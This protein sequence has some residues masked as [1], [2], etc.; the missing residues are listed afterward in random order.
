MDMLIAAAKNLERVVGKHAADVTT[1]EGM[2]AAREQGHNLANRARVVAAML[3][4]APSASPEWS[5]ASAASGARRQRASVRR[6]V[7]DAV[8]LSATI[9]AGAHMRH[10]C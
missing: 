9:V 7:N 2:L 5:G 10:A 8:G 4:G 1:T 3:G 6:S